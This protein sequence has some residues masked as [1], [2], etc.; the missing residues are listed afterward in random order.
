MR[1]LAGAWIPL[2]SFPL[3]NLFLILRFFSIR[4][5]TL[6]SSLSLSLSADRMGQAFI[7]AA[8]WGVCDL[9]PKS[10]ICT[11][12]YQTPPTEHPSLPAFLPR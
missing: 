1:D 11:C 8:R 9:A 2:R 12:P 10:L 3:L 7:G 6:L 4:Y 5:L